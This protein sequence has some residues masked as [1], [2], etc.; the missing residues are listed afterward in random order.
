MTG[1]L[2][3]YFLLKCETVK[4]LMLTVN[5]YVR[6]EG[7]ESHYNVQSSSQL[8]GITLSCLQNLGR[9]L[10]ISFSLYHGP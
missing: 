2:P 5:K 6:F 8:Q 7:Q 3:G 1:Y 10:T 4:W 9:F